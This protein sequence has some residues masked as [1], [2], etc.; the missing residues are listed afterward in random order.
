MRSRKPSHAL[1]DLPPRADA[2]I[3]GETLKTEILG[4][5][6]SAGIVN[7]E[8]HLTPSINPVATSPTA[9]DDVALVTRA[10]EGDQAAF[11][12]LVKEYRD[13]KSTRLNSS[14]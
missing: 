14:H 7:S 3:D 11:T 12:A 1:P 13:R 5:Q 8:P 6:S 2:S 10:Q 4:F 9:F